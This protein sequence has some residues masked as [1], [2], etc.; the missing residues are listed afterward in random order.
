MEVTAEGEAV[1]VRSFPQ[2]L[3]I[4]SAFDMSSL[5]CERHQSLHFVHRLRGQ[6][7]LQRAVADFCWEN[8]ISEMNCG[9]LASTIS[10]RVARLHLAKE[11][12]L[13]AVQ[14][15]PTAQNPFVFIHIEKTGGTTVRE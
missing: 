8:H 13:G 11:L 12:S 14:Q 1:S 15:I 9:V 6:R 5:S 2:L 10:S 3:S 4:D 7:Q